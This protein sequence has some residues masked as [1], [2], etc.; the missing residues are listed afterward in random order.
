MFYSERNLYVTISTLVFCVM[1]IITVF[2]GLKDE[3]KELKEFEWQYFRTLWNYIDIPAYFFSLISTSLLI[4]IIFTTNSNFILNFVYRFINGISI[5]FLWL[6]F[7][8]YSRA[9]EETAFIV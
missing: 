7:L 8:G 3:L 2:S 9:Y 6:K 1:I 5:L 4:V